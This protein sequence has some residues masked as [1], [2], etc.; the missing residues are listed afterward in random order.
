[1][2]RLMVSVVGTVAL[3]AGSAHAGGGCNYG[4]HAAAEESEAAVVASAEETDPELLA[5]LKKQ[6]AEAEALDTL[7]ETPVIHN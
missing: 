1:M 2:R 6:Q 3:M 4:S 7:I 5:K